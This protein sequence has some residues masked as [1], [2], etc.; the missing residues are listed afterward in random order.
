MAHWDIRSHGETTALCGGWKKNTDPNWHEDWGGGKGR[1]LLNWSEKLREVAPSKARGADLL[2]A[3]RLKR[4]D[5]GDMILWQRA[6]ETNGDV[7]TAPAQHH[8]DT[9]VLIGQPCPLVLI[10]GIGERLRGSLWTWMSAVLSEQLVRGPPACPWCCSQRL[11]AGH[12]VN[13]ADT[14]SIPASHR[15]LTKALIHTYQL[16]STTIQGIHSS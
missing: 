15:A 8:R 3:G 13:P 14:I 1:V 16:H 10:W 11:R 4:T 6:E 9:W 5:H 7:S 2:S 12:P